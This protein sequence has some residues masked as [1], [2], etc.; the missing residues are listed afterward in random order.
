M[1][2]RLAVASGIPLEIPEEIHQDALMGKEQL[3]LLTT[4]SPGSGFGE[5]SERGGQDPTTF[6]IRRGT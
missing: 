6:E 3:V 1:V 2:G 4:L 5:R